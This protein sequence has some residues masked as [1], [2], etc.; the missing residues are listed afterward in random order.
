[1]PSPGLAAA[2]STATDRP[3]DGFRLAI[4]VG[5]LIGSVLIFVGTLLPWEGVDTR[6]AEV[7]LNG[8]DVGYVTDWRDTDGKDGVLTLLM[9]TS[10]GGLSV[11]YLNRRNAW[12]SVGIEGLG[13]GAVVVAVHNLMMLSDDIRESLDIS[14]GDAFDYVGEGLY[15]V[16]VGGVVTAV[17]AFVG[18]VGASRDRP[19]WRNDPMYCPA[20]RTQVPEGSAFCHSCGVKA[21]I[22]QIFQQPRGLNDAEVA[23]ANVEAPLPGK[24]A[25]PGARTRTVH[26]SSLRPAT[27]G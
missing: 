27:C 23:E 10:A 16:M 8:F 4:T 14:G 2:A 13:L 15:I 9:A 3:L 19:P 25:M 11:L 12:A 1:M 7:N 5:V 21:R 26:R 20:C 22:P 17:V 24:Q 18:L 6:G